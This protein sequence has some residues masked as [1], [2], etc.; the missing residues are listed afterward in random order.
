[1]VGQTY[2]TTSVGPDLDSVSVSVFVFISACICVCGV[3]TCECVCIFLD[4]P[5]CEDTCVWWSKVDT[6]YLLWFSTLYIEVWSLANPN[7]H[8]V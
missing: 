3:H 8:P 2:A 6:E 4:T 1:M 5:V 7:I